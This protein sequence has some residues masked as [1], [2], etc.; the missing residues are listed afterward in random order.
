MSMAMIGI[1]FDLRAPA[2]GTATHAEL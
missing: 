1:R 2:C